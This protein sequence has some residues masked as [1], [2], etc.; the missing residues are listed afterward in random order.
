MSFI[1]TLWST[2]FGLY[3]DNTSTYEILVSCGSCDT[4]N[5]RNHCYELSNYDLICAGK[6]KNIYKITND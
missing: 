4:K 1:S 3:V 5:Y 2:C 6:T